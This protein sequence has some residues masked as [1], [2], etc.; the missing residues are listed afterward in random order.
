MPRSTPTEKR[1]SQTEVPQ[2]RPGLWTRWQSLLGAPVS[3][4]SLAIFRICV[5][6]IMALEAY[7]LCRPSPSTNNRI[8]LEVFYTSPAIKLHFPY[9]PFAWLPLLPPY[10][11]HVIVGLLALGGILLALG[12]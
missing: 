3:G 12:F 7:S 4:A 2:P 1:N 9:A 5:G 8:P 11:I 10:W 6:V